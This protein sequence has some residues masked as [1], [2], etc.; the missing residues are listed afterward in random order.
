[1]FDLKMSETGSIRKITRTDPGEDARREFLKTEFFRQ[2]RV[3]KQTKVVEDTTIMRHLRALDSKYALYRE[4]YFKDGVYFI[5]LY[6]IDFWS[7]KSTMPIFEEISAKRF[8][9][10]LE[11]KSESFLNI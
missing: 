2:F 8:L 1:M 10:N 3:T 11:K 5:N 4:V 9:K 6:K 7:H